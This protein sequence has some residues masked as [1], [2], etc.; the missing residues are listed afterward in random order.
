MWIRL[1]FN[2]KPSMYFYVFAW[3]V[4][5]YDKFKIKEVMQISKK[6]KL[7]KGINTPYPKM[8]IFFG[9][10]LNS[11]WAEVPAYKHLYILV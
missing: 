7:T 1:M 2:V 5:Y 10:V 6:K 3:F 8:W 9:D 11:L 4:L